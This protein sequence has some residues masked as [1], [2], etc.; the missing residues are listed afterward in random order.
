MVIELKPKKKLGGKSIATGGV[1]HD[2][3]KR[4][5]TGKYSSQNEDTANDKIGLFSPN[6]IT[7]RGGGAAACFSLKATRGVDVN[8]TRIIVHSSE[9][10]DVIAG[11]NYFERPKSAPGCKSSNMVTGREPKGQN[12]ETDY[13]EKKQENRP[14]TTADKPNKY[15]E[16]T[17]ERL[18]KKKSLSM[19]ER[20]EL[21]LAKK[22]TRAEAM[23]KAAKDK[24]ILGMSCPDMR[25]SRRSFGGSKACANKSTGG[26]ST[27]KVTKKKALTA[28]LN[29]ITNR[30]TANKKKNKSNRNKGESNSTTHVKVTESHRKVGSTKSDSD[31][32]NRSTTH[33]RGRTIFPKNFLPQPRDRACSSS[34]THITLPDNDAEVMYCIEDKAAEALSLPENNYSSA[35]LDTIGDENRWVNEKNEPLSVEN[36]HVS[37]EWES[38][39]ND[40]TPEGVVFS[41][42]D[43]EN[44]RRSIRVRRENLFIPSSMYKK[45]DKK[46]GFGRAIAILTGRYEAPPHEEKPAEII[47]DLDAITEDQAREWWSKNRPRF[48]SPKKSKDR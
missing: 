34:D 6:K 41:K 7:V 5:S 47:F 31:F 44:N 20:Q 32:D 1:S 26:N 25:R 30:G 38:A 2:T 45:R 27:Q 39:P 15:P 33:K 14:T 18:E 36:G 43:K 46:S 40:S 4:A 9:G 8:S 23:L 17:I 29:D 10:V 37:F 48:E 35:V 16:P 21:W 13:V 19:L 24:E 12:I 3:R 42:T 11:A 28:G 22:T